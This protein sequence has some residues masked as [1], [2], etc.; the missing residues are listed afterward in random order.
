MEVNKSL[1]RINQALIMPDNLAKVV[2]NM[3]TVIRSLSRQSLCLVCGNMG[4]DFKVTLCEHAV[5][6]D[7]WEEY[8]CGNESIVR[9]A[10][11]GSGGGQGFLLYSTESRRT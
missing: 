7:C 6:V 1:A 10:V 11:C 4:K 8:G 2:T 3:I 9:C 5:C